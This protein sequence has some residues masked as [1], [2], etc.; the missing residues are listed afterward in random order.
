M[1][2]YELT[3]QI[4][5]AIIDVIARAGLIFILGVLYGIYLVAKKEKQEGR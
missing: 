3:I 2:E 5:S 4:I 1:K